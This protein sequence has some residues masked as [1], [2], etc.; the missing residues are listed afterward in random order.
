MIKRLGMREAILA[1]QL[2]K[3]I[4]TARP[5]P[6]LRPVQSATRQGSDGLLERANALRSRRYDDGPGSALLGRRMTAW[7]FFGA[8][9]LVSQLRWCLPAAVLLIVATVIKIALLPRVE[10][11]R[12]MRELSGSNYNLHGTR[13][14]KRPASAPVQMEWGPTSNCRL[15]RSARVR[16]PSKPAVTTM[17]A[18]TIS[19]RADER[20]NSP[21]V[22]LLLNYRK[23][24]ADA[25]QPSI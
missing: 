1:P 6:R 19:L 9:E 12:L 13:G 14:S 23:L 16:V 5:P 24:M 20:C 25:L 18:T 7:R 17:W 3:R 22:C 2:R 8:E 15:V 11:C 21:H 10:T 4:V